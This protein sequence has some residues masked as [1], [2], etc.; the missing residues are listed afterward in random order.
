MRDRGLLF[1]GLMAFAAGI[2]GLVLLSAGVL[3]PRVMRS[4]AVARGEWI[5]RTGADLDGRPLP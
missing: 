1:A 4:D 5:F 3:V 2:L